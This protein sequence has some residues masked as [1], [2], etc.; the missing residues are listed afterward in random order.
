MAPVSLFSSYTGDLE[1]FGL[2]AETL[3]SSRNRP[4]FGFAEART[5]CHTV[6][7][8]LTIHTTWLSGWCF[9]PNLHT[10]PKLSGKH[11][12]H[13]LIFV[14]LCQT[15]GNSP[16]G[17][18]TLFI[19]PKCVALHIWGKVKLILSGPSASADMTCHHL[20]TFDVIHI[21]Y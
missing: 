5:K 14:G 1:T 16:C 4:C 15:I 12:Q 10:R 13:L 21:F 9:C 18:M 2:T 11:F 3:P 20:E 6:S 7:N 19:F 8:T 17:D